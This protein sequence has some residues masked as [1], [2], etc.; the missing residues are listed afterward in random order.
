MVGRFFARLTL[1]AVTGHMQTL[2]LRPPGSAVEWATHIRRV[3]TLHTLSPEFP[4]SQIASTQRYSHLSSKTLLEAADTAAG[5]S[6][7]TMQ[8]S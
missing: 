7:I 4:Y 2:V 6:G 5:A 8:D 1:A 3:R